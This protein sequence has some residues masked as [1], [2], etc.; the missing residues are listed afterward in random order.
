M[1]DTPQL[2]TIFGGGGFIGRYAAEALLKSGVRLRVAERKPKSAYKLQPLGSVGQV[3]LMSADITRPD[4][5]ARAVEGA[6]AVINLVGIF[7]GDLEA[8]HVDGARNV[9]EEAKKAGAKSVVHIS[10]IGA[11]PA[12]PSRYGSSKGRGEDAVRD[13]FA[14]ATILRP[15]VVFGQEDEFTNRFAQMA[16]MPVLPVLKPNTRFQPVYV[17]DLGKAIAKAALDPKTHGGK[18]YEIGG[19][20]QYSMHDLNQKIARLAGRHPAVIDLPDAFGSLMS[21]FGWLPGAPMTGD[22]WIMLQSDNVVSDDAATLADMGITPT[23][24]GQ[25]APSWL[26]RYKR[27]GRFADQLPA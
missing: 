25:V 16:A 5:V 22:Q 3:A 26:G 14:G 24:L 18:T 27:G 19:P 21:K 11:D 1:S 8:V 17:S 2:V 13:A 20:E 12:A 9:A 23:P 7:N 15:S 6:D 4:T 10:A